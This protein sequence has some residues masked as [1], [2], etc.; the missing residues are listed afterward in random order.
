MRRTISELFDWNKNREAEMNTEIDKEK[1]QIENLKNRAYIVSKEAVKLH[2]KQEAHYF[3]SNHF[4]NLSSNIE[5]RDYFQKM[6]LKHALHTSKFKRAFWAKVHEE[7][8]ELESHSLRYD[9][10][11]RSVFIQPSD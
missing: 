7:F 4:S 2:T 5:N 10:G 9:S 11:S 1:T 3:L 8:P 6:A